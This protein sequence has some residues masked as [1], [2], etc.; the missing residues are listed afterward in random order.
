M[1][2][3]ELW[4]VAGGGAFTTNTRPAV[5]V[6]DSLAHALNSVAI[7]LL[8]S[9]TTDTLAVRPRIEPN[10]LNGLRAPSQVM[11]DKIAAVPRAKLSTRIGKLTDADMLQ[12]NRALIVFLGLAG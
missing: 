4:T 11:I 12:V 6:P 9:I 2:R 7:C 3:G 5:L 1:D 10:K 8:T